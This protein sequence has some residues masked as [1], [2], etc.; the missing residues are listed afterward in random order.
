MT[1][2]DIELI[3]RATK[4][5]LSVEEKAAFER[6]LATDE[7]FRALNEDVKSMIAAIRTVAAEKT[8]Q[9]TTKEAGGRQVM[10]RDPRL[11]AAAAT[12]AIATFLWL[13]LYTERSSDLVNQYYTTYTTFELTQSRGA[14]ES[15]DL[16]SKA[17]D[18]YKAHEIARA[19]ALL[20][21]AL[22]IDPEDEEAIFLTGICHLDE[23]NYQKALQ[24]FEAIQTQIG[25]NPEWQWYE[26]LTRLGLKQYGRCRELL[27]EIEKSGK[28]P[29]ATKAAELKNKLPED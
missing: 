17:L 29:Y 1:E 8:L 2:E 7:S 14:S 3:E 11:W 19:M 24:A 4:G 5:A 9:Q 16:K 15:Y 18:A 23:S 22:A 6:R 13:W 27:T 25:R 21:S 28:A 12:I 20:D 10:W 26:A